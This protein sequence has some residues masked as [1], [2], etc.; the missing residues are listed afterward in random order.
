MSTPITNARARLVDAMRKMEAG[1]LANASTAD[2]TQLGS[3]F[4]MA[5]RQYATQ[6]AVA[7]PGLP[8]DQSDGCVNPN[9]AECQ[10]TGMCHFIDC[11]NRSTE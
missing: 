8:N 1:H 6:I 9:P 11:P 2:K 3:I 4:I 5:A 10:Q 7:V